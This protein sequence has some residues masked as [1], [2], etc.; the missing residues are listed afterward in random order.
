MCASILFVFYCGYIRF[1]TGTGTVSLS[2]PF[3]SM[4]VV[5]TGGLYVFVASLVSDKR[6]EFSGLEG[7][8][9]QLAALT[10]THNVTVSR[11]LDT[12]SVSFSFFCSVSL[13]L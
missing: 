3:A 2:S 5:V 8:Y 11:G 12:C 1:Q 4:L 13:S 7:L 6:D 9:V 10:S